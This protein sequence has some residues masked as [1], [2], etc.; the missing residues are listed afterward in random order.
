MNKVFLQFSIVNVTQVK[1]LRSFS[2]FGLPVP[3]LYKT[4]LDINPFLMLLISEKRSRLQPVYNVLSLSSAS[5]YSSHHLTTYPKPR[6]SRRTYWSSLPL[7]ENPQQPE[8]AT[9][10]SQRWTPTYEPPHSDDVCQTSCTLMQNRYGGL[11]T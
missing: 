5:S 1:Y 4:G 2:I 6:G 3:N 8:T 10:R 9:A 11:R 7:R